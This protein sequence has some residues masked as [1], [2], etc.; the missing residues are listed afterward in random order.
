MNR[1]I[2][3]VDIDYQPVKNQTQFWAVYFMIFIILGNFLIL[4]LFVGVVIST[5]NKEKE[6]LGKGNLLSSR[7]KEW[8]EMK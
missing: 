3:S 5:F 7:Q 4:N 8:L 6:I 1:G 2:D